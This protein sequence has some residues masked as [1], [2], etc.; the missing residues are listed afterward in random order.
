MII[1]GKWGMES[2]NGE[3][4]MERG[5]G[6]EVNAHH[7]KLA[8]EEIRILMSTSGDAHLKHLNEDEQ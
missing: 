2:E 6:G 7:E 3:W 4:K 1:W 5:Q 8:R